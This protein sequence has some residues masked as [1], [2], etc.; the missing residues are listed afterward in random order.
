VNGLFARALIAFLTLPGVVAFVIPL[1]VLRRPDVPVHVSGVLIVAIGALVLVRCVRDFYLV[2]KGTLAPWSPP[3]TLV[4]VGLYEY[5]RNP[6]Y[7]GVILILIGWAVTYWT[8][9]HASYAVLMMLVFY[10]RVVAFE[11]PGL[12]SR[13]GEAWHAYRSRVRRRFL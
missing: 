7:V 11:E 8:K 3:A 5:S 13:H 4:T 1:W 10:V 12:A 6:M 9:A 2:G